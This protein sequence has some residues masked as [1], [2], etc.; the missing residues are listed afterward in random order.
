MTEIGA[1]ANSVAV[2]NGII[3]V[4]IENADKQAFG[5]V[6]FFN[7]EGELLNQVTVGALP[8]MVTLLE[9]FYQDYY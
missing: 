5:I 6:A 3:A 9:A 1:S 8:N 7:T 4:A 2:K